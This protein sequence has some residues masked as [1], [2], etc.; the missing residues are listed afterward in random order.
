[1]DRTQKAMKDLQRLAGA[2][3]LVLGISS[4]VLMAAAMTPIK[5]TPWVLAGPVVM[6]LA[7]AYL[8]NKA[9]A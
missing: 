1:M 9:G 4:V 3:L 2:V 5:H 7:G 8:A 6:M